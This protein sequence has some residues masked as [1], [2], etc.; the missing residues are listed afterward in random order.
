MIDPRGTP[1]TS[2]ASCG[3]CSAKVG[4]GDL[5]KILAA[6]ATANGGIDVALD[7]ELLVGTETGDDAAVLRI[8]DQLALVATTDFVTPVC[9]DPYLYGQVAAANALSDVFAMGGL[10]IL[11]LAICCFPDAASGRRSLVPW[12]WS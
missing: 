3:G 2:L 5:R 6:V 9:D 7:P 4:P 10:P 12:R 8:D 11:A 1:I